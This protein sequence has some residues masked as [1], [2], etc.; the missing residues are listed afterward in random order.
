MT[1]SKRVNFRYII[2]AWLSVGFVSMNLHND[3]MTL[4][5]S[6][7][8]PGHKGKAENVLDRLMENNEDDALK[9]GYNLD[10]ISAKKHTLKNVNR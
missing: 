7:L 1:F 8:A 10:T 6:H 5:Y 2:T 3:K 4:R 9:N